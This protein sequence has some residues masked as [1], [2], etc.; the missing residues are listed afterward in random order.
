MKAAKADSF[1]H[2]LETAGYKQTNQRRRV[3]EVI[4]KN[5]DRHL[6]VEEV[7]DELKKSKCRVGLATVYRT[8]KLFEKVGFIR[9]IVLDDGDLRYQII[10]PEEKREHQ[11]L[12][13]EICGEVV[14]IQDSIDIPKEQLEDI[15]KKVFT[16]K[17]FIVTNQKVQLYGICKNCSQRV[18]S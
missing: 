4:I 9:H 7:Y 8:I 13:C 1:D 3:L 10:D 6:S 12:I 18:G 14:D 16:E 11:H 2:I 5:R 15:E 17:G